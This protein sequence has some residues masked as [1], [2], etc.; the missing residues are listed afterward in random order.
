MYP[1]P[2]K[3]LFLV[4][5]PFSNK[6]YGY[7]DCNDFDFDI[8]NIGILE[9]KVQKILIYHST[10]DHLVPFTHAEYFKQNIPTAKLITFTDRGHFIGPEF[11]EIN[12]EI[13][14]IL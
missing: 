1:S 2:I 3:A 6:E 12:E 14:K 8:K 5:T 4:A 7:R 9:K 13:R 10:D 11:P